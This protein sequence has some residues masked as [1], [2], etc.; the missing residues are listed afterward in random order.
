MTKSQRKMPVATQ[1]SRSIGIELTYVNS[2]ALSEIAI[3]TQ[4]VALSSQG[5]AN[6][7]VVV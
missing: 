5:A 3:G 7:K 6:V 2:D 4:D 1:T